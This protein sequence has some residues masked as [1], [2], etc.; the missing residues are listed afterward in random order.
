MKCTL[1]NLAGL[2]SFRRRLRTITI[3]GV[4]KDQLLGLMH[5]MALQSGI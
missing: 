5:G 4:N 2:H 1:K 3:L